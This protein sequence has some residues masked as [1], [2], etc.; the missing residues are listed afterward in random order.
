MNL[1]NKTDT[2]FSVGFGTVM[3]YLAALTCFLLAMFYQNFFITGL[4]LGTLLFAVSSA[5]I[6]VMVKMRMET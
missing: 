5:I 3:L 6:G 1:I 4:A 2:M